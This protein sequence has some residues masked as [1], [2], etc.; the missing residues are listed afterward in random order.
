MNIDG[1]FNEKKNYDVFFSIGTK[2]MKI[3][4][5]ARCSA[6]AELKLKDKLYIEKVV[7]QED[8]DTSIEKTLK[9]IFQQ[10]NN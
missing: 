1:F 4:I 2:K 10:F 5:E 8:A 9:N 6:E 7:C 3:S